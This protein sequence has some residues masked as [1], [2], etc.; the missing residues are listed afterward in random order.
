[1]FPYMIHTEAVDAG[2][3]YWT[4]PW[5]ALVLN[6]S[7]P[8]QNGRRFA[9]DMLRRI[10]VNGKFCILIEISQK[11]VPYSLIDNDPALVEIMAWHRIG[12]TPLSEPILTGFTVAYMRR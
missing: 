5:V 7:P 3:I 10:L 1:M 2:V 6:T 8:G 4:N 9:D 11:S 12:D